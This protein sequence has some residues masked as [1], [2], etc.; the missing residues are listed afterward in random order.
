MEK[1]AHHTLASRRVALLGAF[2][3]F[4]SSV[5]GNRNTSAEGCYYVV[6]PFTAQQTKT[7]HLPS[8]DPYKVPSIKGII[9]LCLLLLRPVYP[10]PQFLSARIY[11]A[12][13][14]NGLATNSYSIC[15]SVSPYQASTDNIYDTSMNGKNTDRAVKKTHPHYSLK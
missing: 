12:Y 1:Q 4:G 5:D 7:N 8:F 10:I 13:Q 15:R 3:S 9:R 2:V 6:L 14:F 11:T